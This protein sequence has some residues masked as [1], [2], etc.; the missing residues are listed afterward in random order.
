[1]IY[2]ACELRSVSKGP[3]TQGWYTECEALSRLQH[4]PVLPWPAHRQQDHEHVSHV[5]AFLTNCLS[6]K[7]ALKLS[8]ARCRQ[9]D[10]ESEKI[11]VLLQQCYS[12]SLWMQLKLHLLLLYLVRRRKKKRKKESINTSTSS[13]L[14]LALSGSMG[15]S[16]WQL[17]KVSKFRQSDSPF[18]QVS[19]SGDNNQ[20]SHDEFHSQSSA[21]YGVGR[22]IAQYWPEINFYLEV[23]WRTYSTQLN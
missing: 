2:I 14:N 15:N 13:L 18:S 10:T 21:D 20:A 4:F 12:N 16:W 17:S 5:I 7:L 11:H 8:G 3:N 19:P 6:L 1:M 22:I 23:L 9:F